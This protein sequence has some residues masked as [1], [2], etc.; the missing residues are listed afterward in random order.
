MGQ[1]EHILPAKSFHQGLKEISIGNGN[2]NGISIGII[3]AIRYTK[4]QK[5]NLDTIMLALGGL[6]LQNDFLSIY[7]IVLKWSGSISIGIRIGISIG[8]SIGI[9]TG[10]SIGIFGI[11]LYEYQ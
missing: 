2:G 4:P 8:I 9:N 5:N 11:F 7:F 10:S 3:I 6:S 1:R